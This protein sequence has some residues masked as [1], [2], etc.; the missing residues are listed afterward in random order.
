MRLMLL[1]LGVA[2]LLTSCALP[3]RWVGGYQP[4]PF[5]SNGQR[6]YLTAESSSGQPIS[7]SG[8]ATMMHQRTACVNCHG[9]DGKGGR[10]NM[11]MWS[12]DTPDITWDNLMEAEGHVYV[13]SENGPMWAFERT[14]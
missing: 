12:F 14:L 8:G 6:I 2:S 5:E 1:I 11:M 3:Y 7:Y 4:G 9:P 10:V 13:V